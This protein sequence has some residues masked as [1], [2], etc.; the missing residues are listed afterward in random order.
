LTTTFQSIGE[1]WIKDLFTLK[2]KI[3]YEM[4]HRLLRFGQKHIPYYFVRGMTGYMLEN[5]K[6]KNLVGV[7]IGTQNGFNAKVM[8]LVLPISKLY[9]VDPYVDYVEDMDVYKKHNKVDISEF[10]TARNLL[11][12]FDNRVVFYR[13]Y[14]DK[15]YN[16]FDDDSLDF[17]YIDGNHSYEFVMNDIL[18]YLPKVKSGGII[19]G[20]DFGSKY[21]GVVQAVFDFTQKHDYNLFTGRD[22]DWWIIKNKLIVRF[23]EDKMIETIDKNEV[24][25]KEL[26]EKVNEIIRALNWLT[27][28]L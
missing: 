7:E 2:D 13:D 21:G 16:R 25:Q 5:Y 12:Q 3:Y 26:I 28:P 15:V 6:H 20:H 11:N 4:V 10:Y 8:M 24:N 1:P 19:G 27:N 23:G 17:V 18:L 22:N 14:S 9:C